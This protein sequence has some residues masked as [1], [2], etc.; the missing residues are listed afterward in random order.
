MDDSKLL[1]LYRK[2]RQH[3]EQLMRNADDIDQVLLELETCLSH[4]GEEDQSAGE[5][6]NFET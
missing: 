4:P 2:L 3:H 6:G 5:L 1:E